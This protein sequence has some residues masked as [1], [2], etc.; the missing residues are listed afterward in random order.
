MIEQQAIE[1][2]IRG[3][4]QALESPDAQGEW[5]RGEISFLLDNQGLTLLRTAEEPQVPNN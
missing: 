5:N 1:A 2:T 3:I 4:A